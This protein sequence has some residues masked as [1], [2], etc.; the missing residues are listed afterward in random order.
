MTN[1][2][3]PM[4]LERKEINRNPSPK[5]D[6]RTSQDPCRSVQ[7]PA[8]ENVRLCRPDTERENVVVEGRVYL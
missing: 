7:H 6:P 1:K 8:A 3:Q 2:Q 4:T 5:V